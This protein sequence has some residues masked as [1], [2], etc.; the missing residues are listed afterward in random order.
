MMT[1][2]SQAESG[3]TTLCINVLNGDNILV[4]SSVRITRFS[5][6]SMFSKNDL[7]LD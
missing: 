4:L 6:I 7:S 5:F 3:C 1:T 2:T